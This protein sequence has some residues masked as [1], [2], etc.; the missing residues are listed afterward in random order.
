MA[1]YVPK[2]KMVTIGDVECYVSW[3][4]GNDRAIIVFQD[5]F[6]IHTGRHKQFCD[7]LLE[8]GYNAVLPDF[9]GKDPLIKNPPQ[10]GMTCSCFFNALLVFCCTGK[11]KMREHSW[12][13]S[14][15]RIV[16]DN[17]V[18]WMKQQGATKLASVGFC[19]G[20]YGAMCCGKYPE[21]FSCDVSFHPSTEMMC[22][23]ANEDALALCRAIKVPQLVVATQMESPEWKPKGAAQQAIEEDGTTTTWLLESKQKHGFMTRGETTDAETMAA[24][25]FYM[26]TMF[27]FLD[28]NVK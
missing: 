24:I 18:P 15:K 4:S 21:I 1:D 10:Y 7:M 22:K 6:G 23:A 8:K 16:I 3:A 25:K 13:A 2:G 12:D 17:V 9:T 28:A 20:S 14:M 19:F 27:E 5:I 11:R 26:Q